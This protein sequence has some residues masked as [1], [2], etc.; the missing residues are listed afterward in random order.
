MSS[1]TVEERWGDPGTQAGAAALDRLRD[2]R[3]GA[4]RQNPGQYA[5]Y[6]Y[7]RDDNE[8]RS[9]GRFATVKDASRAVALIQAETCIEAAQEALGE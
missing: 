7:D 4:D 6:F 3:I 5:V 1:H 9:C 2:A 8:V